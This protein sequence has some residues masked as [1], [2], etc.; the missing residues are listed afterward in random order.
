MTR[1]SD[2]FY[3]STAAH[4]ADAAGFP[5]GDTRTRARRGLYGTRAASAAS[6]A[7]DGLAAAT[8][9]SELCGSL[10]RLWATRLYGRREVA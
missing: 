9:K 8:A 1:R 5:Y 6:A 3:R 10:A 4:A 7:V 2:P